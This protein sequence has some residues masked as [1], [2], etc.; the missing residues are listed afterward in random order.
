MPF[1]QTSANSTFDLKTHTTT[2]TSFNQTS[3]KNFIL[4]KK[5]TIIENNK[6]VNELN[7]IYF[8]YNNKINLNDYYYT[9]TFSFPDYFN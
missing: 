4:N 2:N 6:K 8:P 9:L 3:K 7:Y 5:K 1:I